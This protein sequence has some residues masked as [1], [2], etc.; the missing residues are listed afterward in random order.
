ML[1]G[2]LSVRVG[3]LIATR[4]IIICIHLTNGTTVA[5]LFVE[6]RRFIGRYRDS[7]LVE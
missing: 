2:S 5:G 6:L 4:Q 1:T 3:K 7:V